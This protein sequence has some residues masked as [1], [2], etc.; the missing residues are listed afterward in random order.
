MSSLL[1]SS[2]LFF[3]SLSFLTFDF[4][5]MF[6]DCASSD[7][8]EIFEVPSS[9]AAFEPSRFVKATDFGVDSFDCRYC[10]PVCFMSI[11]PGLI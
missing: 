2:K 7:R 8:F 6:C 9:L 4:R 11:E 1:R 3:S 10:V 5:I